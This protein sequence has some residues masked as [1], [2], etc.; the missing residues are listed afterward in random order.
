MAGFP[1]RYVAREVRDNGKVVAY[2]ASPAHLFEE[3]KRYDLAGRIEERYEI[4]FVTH[5]YGEDYEIENGHAYTKYYKGR[6]DANFQNCI[7]YVN[8]LNRKL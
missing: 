3:R 2:F 6:V 8:A 7:D 1:I 4:D 5:I